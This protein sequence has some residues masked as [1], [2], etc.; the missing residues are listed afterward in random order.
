MKY[1]IWRKSTDMRLSVQWFLSFSE[2][3]LYILDLKQK[4]P[5]TRK[6]HT[7]N[8]HP[9]PWLS[10]LGRLGWGQVQWE[11]NANACKAPTTQLVKKKNYRNSCSLISLHVKQD[12]QQRWNSFNTYYPFFNEKMSF[13]NGVHLRNVQMVFI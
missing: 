4:S 3:S 13:K 11:S 7:I 6:R 1:N 12:K 2:S 5:L 9:M 8:S 10:T